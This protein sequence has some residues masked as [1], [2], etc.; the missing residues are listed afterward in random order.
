MDE[1]FKKRWIVNCCPA[2]LCMPAMHAYDHVDSSR[3]GLMI[4]QTTDLLLNLSPYLTKRFTQTY[5]RDGLNLSFPWQ[6]ILSLHL[7]G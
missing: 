5:S 2:C 6:I 4:L 1:N 7:P 3:D